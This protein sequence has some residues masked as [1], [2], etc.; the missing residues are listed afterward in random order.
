MRLSL[1]LA[2]ITLVIP[3]ISQTADDNKA[4]SIYAQ[5][6]IK[7]QIS[8]DYPYTGGKPAKTGTKTS[9]TSLTATGDI[10]QVTTY[11]AKGLVLNIE[12]YKYD[13]HGNKTEYSRYSG[14]NQEKP[15]YQKLSKYS[16]K[17][18]ILEESGFDG[19]ENFKNVYNYSPQGDITEI[20]Y[21]KN[22][23]LKEKR[24]FTKNGNITNVA[25]YNSMGA[26][27]S[28]MVLTYDDRNNL[29]E[30]SI[31]GINQSAIEKKKYNYDEN[32]KLKEEA[33][34]SLDK[35]TLKTYYN[36]NASGDLLEISDEN[37]SSA[38]FIKKT[39]SYDPNG[40]LVEIQWRRKD[41][42]E[43]NRIS[44]TYDPKGLC[45]TADTY[46]PATKYRVLTKYVYEGN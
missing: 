38:R 8:W 7:N 17:D 5:N 28:R 25:I 42:E 30:E 21:L 16:E 27:T 33:K 20:R 45:T 14:G 2:F 43:F 1:S 18:L 24:V 9:V 46:Y 37:P 29:V 4:R 44:Y 31:Y 6:R 39:F 3:A 15:A 36:Y 19:V 11:N 23:T 10:S 40:R 34:Y 26:L 22:T 35:I 12:K 41:K 32:K 13:A